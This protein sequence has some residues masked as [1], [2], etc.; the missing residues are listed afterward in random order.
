MRRKKYTAAEQ[1]QWLRDHMEHDDARC[2]RWPFVYDD[3]V[4][5]GRILYEGKNWWAHRLMC[6][7]VN[8]PAPEDK[9]QSA[10]SCGNGHMGCVHPKHLSWATQ[11]ENHKDRRKHGTAATNRY[12][13]RT[14]LTD[15][16]VAQIRA[17]K[18]RQTQMQTAREFGISH[19]SVRRWQATNHEPARPGV[20]Y[21]ALRRRRNRMIG[22]G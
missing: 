3:G 22:C 17:L 14:R 6:T 12:G 9:P 8:G 15:E 18:G 2:L 4:G 5:R 16:Q 21:D 7:L 11:S 19:A 20:S 1:F 10:H 13:P